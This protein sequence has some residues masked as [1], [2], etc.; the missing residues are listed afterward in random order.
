M[1]DAGCGAGG[2]SA[3]L[4]WHRGFIAVPVQHPRQR[5][6]SPCALWVFS[7]VC[8]CLPTSSSF[9]AVYRSDDPHQKRA[10][11]LDLQVLSP[12]CSGHRLC[13][14]RVLCCVALIPRAQSGSC[15]WAMP[16]QLAHCRCL[17]GSSYYLSNIIII[18]HYLSNKHHVALLL[19]AKRETAK[20]FGRYCPTAAWRPSGEVQIQAWI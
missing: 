9:P 12:G 10:D 2:F 14:R 3:A 5:S 11:A 6:S 20:L 15:R 1:R 17:L 13:C 8:C 7:C 18:S 16:G 4:L 19:K